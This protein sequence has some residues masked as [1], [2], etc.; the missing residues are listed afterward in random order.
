MSRANPPNA[1]ERLPRTLVHE[2]GSSPRALFPQ[3]VEPTPRR[4]QSSSTTTMAQPMDLITAAVTVTPASFAGTFTDA[5]RRDPACACQR[6][7]LRVSWCRGPLSSSG[8]DCQ[9]MDRRAEPLRPKRQSVSH[10]R[11]RA[12]GDCAGRK[13]TNGR[14]HGLRVNYIK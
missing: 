4:K 10:A 9:G 13:Q 12:Y 6:L 5:R 3:W 14:K 7:S 11:R 8:G 2:A 1:G